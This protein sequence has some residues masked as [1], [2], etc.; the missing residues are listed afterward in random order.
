MEIKTSLR[1]STLAILM[2]FGA[3]LTPT[4]RADYVF[5][6]DGSTYVDIG[7]K[8]PLGDSV[9]LSAWVRISPSITND[10][11]KSTSGSDTYWGAGI[12]GQG[13]WGGTTGLGMF[14]GASITTPQTSDDKFT[15]QVRQGDDKAVGL[16]FTNST[17][18]TEN[19]WHHYLLVRDKASGE[20]RLYADGA[21]AA[22]SDFGSNYTLYSN[23]STPKKTTNFAI[24]KNMAG[25]G[26]IFRGY[27]AEVAI[28]GEALTAADAVLLTRRSPDEIGKAPYAYF[29]L[30]EG[31]G[32][33]ITNKKNGAQ[34]SKSG[35]TLRWVNDANFF[36]G[37]TGTI[38][39]TGGPCEVGSPDPGYGEYE[40][41]VDD[42]VPFSC[43]A[44]ATTNGQPL[45][46]CVGWRLELADGTVFTGENTSTNVTFDHSFR[47]ATF[48]WL[49]NATN[50]LE[51]VVAAEAANGGETTTLYPATA[52]AV[53]PLAAPPSWTN[54]A[55]DT[56]VIFTGWK[57]FDAAG[58]EVDDGGDTAFTYTH[59]DP[60][61]FRRLVWQYHHE[62]RVTA[63]AEPGLTVTPAVQWVPEGE[64]ATVIAGGDAFMRWSGASTSTAA[65]LKLLNVTSPLAVTA[66]AASNVRYVGE[67]GMD[68]AGHGLSPASPYASVEHAVA[69]LKAN[70]GGV[71]QVAAGH[72]A[73]TQTVS[74][75]SA[76]R[77]VGAG[78]T[79]TWLNFGAKRR[80]FS[81][82]DDNACVD[83]LA[84]SNAVSG[85]GGGASISKGCI[86][87]CLFANC[88]ANSSHGG[89]AY[90]TGGIVEDCEFTK[91]TATALYSHGNAIY[92]NGGTVA[93]CDIHHCDGG[94]SHSDPRYGSAVVY[95]N[96]GTFRHS[97]VHHNVKDTD[98]GIH[99]VGGTVYSCLVYANTGT[100]TAGSAGIH[101]TDGT[102]YNCTV[103]GN[104]VQ[105]ETSGVSGINQTGGTTRNCILF[106]N[107]PSASVAGS[108]RITGGTFAKNLIDV[109]L[110]SY[111]DNRVTGDPKFVNPAN[112]DYHLASRASPAYAYGVPTLNGMTDLDRRL[113]DKTSPSAGCYEYDASGET[114]GVDI[115]FEQNDYRAGASVSLV[116]VLS[117]AKPRE[118]SFAWYVDGS[119]TPAGTGDT[120]TLENLAPGRHS[121]R[122]VATRTADAATAEADYPDSIALHPVVCYVNT[123]GS[124]TFPYAT[125]ET[126]TN[127]I[128][129]ALAALWTANDVTSVIH[130]AEGTYRLTTT[131]S[132]L[133]KVRIVG[134]GRDVTTVTGFSGLAFSVANSAAGVSGITVAN[135]LKGFSVGAGFV[136]D[137]RARNL[138]NTE[139]ST[140]ACAFA[141]SGGRIESCEAVNCAITCLY[142]KGAGF[143]VSGSGA[144][145]SNCLARNCTAPSRSDGVGGGIYL[146]AGKV[147]HSAVE[148]CSGIGD[149]GA[150]YATGASSALLWCTVTN[151]Q[152]GKAG[153]TAVQFDGAS[154]LNC[155][156]ARNKSTT[157]TTIALIGAT[158]DSCTMASNSATA[159]AISADA[160][161]KIYNSILADNAGAYSFAAGATF[162]HCCS[163][164]LAEDENGN[165]PDA[166]R[167]R[168]PERDDFRLGVGS[169]CINNADASRW[170]SRPDALD[171]NGLPRRI[172]HDYDIGCYEFQQ[173]A[174]YLMIQ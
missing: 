54:A 169:R 150:V 11:P 92:L 9:S 121:V 108:C 163:P 48:T 5:Y 71:V 45:A 66:T 139:Y 158:I 94:Y 85:T 96:S 109:T 70:G 122:L 126:A 82:S 156:F 138:T 127:S 120:I 91:C 107:G 137:C 140:S 26:G 172:G 112:N 38:T 154:A 141:I 147:T 153:K 72:Y 98:P 16:N 19:A 39:V 128:N 119:G 7:T 161:S 167:F 148:G 76:I 74:I 12:V 155:L 99:Q 157:G 3:V 33:K 81:V 28:W 115:S 110:S 17:L 116:G 84:I 123:T 80:G 13:Y 134:A 152:A 174:T 59:P 151:C 21:L 27:V 159:T 50:T 170:T 1:S 173:M 78:P 23:S 77:V 117:G 90:V 129:E 56:A 4:S 25:V 6:L 37:G 149:G 111:A 103:V 165:F 93:G 8:Y 52:G 15:C 30:G 124:G 32:T 53:I 2:S 14:V 20:A 168:H 166:P 133:K 106:G 160:S 22:R 46:A 63:S 97:A 34:Y 24:G 105:N 10:P 61:A 102:T 132:L 162:S 31:S 145:V 87:N 69:D 42:V 65:N 57:L 143:N 29:P 142:G 125:P 58:N 88:T 43:P 49:W 101:K 35:G 44:T 83:G 55:G 130:V 146:T 113:F 164:A 68:E 95:V 67:D 60:A 100:K 18:F 171:L 41:M 64:A 62:Y 104:V 131:V 51:V 118:V 47:N 86:R 75:A 135:G 40:F 89:G 136:R 36:R 144:V 79:S 73:P 114:F